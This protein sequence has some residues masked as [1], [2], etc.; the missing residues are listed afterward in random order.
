MS[1]CAEKRP[2]VSN[3]QMKT[4]HLP[5]VSPATYVAIPDL[6]VNLYQNK[7]TTRLQPINFASIFYNGPYQ[8]HHI[9]L[10]QKFQLPPSTF[11]RGSAGSVWQVLRK[12]INFH[13]FT[14]WRAKP[15]KCTST[16]IKNNLHILIK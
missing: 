6:D 2:F 9:S 15:K 10:A 13:S 16:S 8:R 4:L 5:I 3:G 12:E 7:A 1:R 14:L 11:T